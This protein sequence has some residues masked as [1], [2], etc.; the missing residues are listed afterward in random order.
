MVEAKIDAAIDR[1]E[2]D[3]Y[4]LP[5]PTRLLSY[6]AGLLTSSGVLWLLPSRAFRIVGVGLGLWFVAVLGRATIDP[7]RLFGPSWLWGAL[8]GP[9]RA[10]RWWAPAI[11]A[12]AAVAVLVG[13]WTLTVAAALF[14]YRP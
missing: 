11:R 1:S 8:I 14:I 6:L 9:Y 3:S 12:G 13:L 10:E 4:C 7:N 5:W 2:A